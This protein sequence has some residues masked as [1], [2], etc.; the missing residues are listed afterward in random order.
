M[1]RN[2][3][4]VHAAQLPHGPGALPLRAGRLGGRPAAG[5]AHRPAPLP[6]ACCW[7]QGVAN[8]SVR[9][10]VSTIRS[11]YKWLRQEGRL[12]NDPFFGVTG[13]KAARRLPDILTPEDIDRMVGGGGRQR[14][15]RPARPGAAGA[16]LRR[17]PARQRGR[18]AGRGGAGR[19]RPQ[20]A[21]A[22]QGQEGAHRR[23]RRAGGDG[24]EPLPARR[25]PG[26]GLAAR[27]RRCSSIA[28]A[29]G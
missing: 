22:R 3:S 20:R 28:S 25:P 26:A 15:G 4:A 18:V 14:A 24:A 6:G 27:R 19:A 29:G 12:E 9:R 17:R 5:A 11:F 1:A 13:P 16:A 10:K 2:L 23:L 8:A 21:G 7:A